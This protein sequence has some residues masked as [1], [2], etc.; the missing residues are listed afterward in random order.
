MRT[1]PTSLRASATSVCAVLARMAAVLLVLAFALLF[2][3]APALAQTTY[4]TT[5][6]GTAAVN[7]TATPCGTPLTR[8]FNVGTSFIVGD[9]DLGVLLEH[10]YRADIII[11]LRSPLGTTVT[12][13]N[14]SGGA[15]DNLNVQFSDEAGTSID[16]DGTN[17]SGPFATTGTTYTNSRSPSA[18]GA[19][20]AFDGENASGSWRLTICD[21]A[22]ADSGTFYRSH[23]ILTPMPTVTGADLSLTK[24]VSNANP[25]N[26]AAISYTLS[27][28]NA[29]NSSLAASGVQVR[30]ILPAGFAFTSAAGFGTYNSGTGIWTVGAIPI[31]TTRTITISGTVSAAGGSTVVNSAEITASGQADPDSTVNNGA[32]GEDDYAFAVFTVGARIAGTP[33]GLTCPIGSS[34]QTFDW[35]ASSWPVN[36]LSN[37][38]AF[39]TVGNTNVNIVT[40][41]AFVTGSP[42]INANLEGGLGG[43]VSLFLNLNNNSRADDAEVTLTLPTAVPQLQFRIHDIDFASGSFADKV[44]VIGR[45]N[46]ATVMPT[47]TNGVSNYVF[48]NI[49]IGDAGSTDAGAGSGNGNVVVTFSSPVDTVVVIYGNHSTAPANP[50]NQWASIHDMNFCSPTA[51]LTVDKSSVVLNDPVNGTSS[52][53]AIPGATVRYCILM[54]N[55]GSGTT[56]AVT[57]TDVLPAT[58]TF[59]PGSLRTGTTCSN[60]TTVEDDDAVGPDENNPHGAAFNAGTVTASLGSIAPTGTMAVTFQA[61]VN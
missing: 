20:S 7:E 33:P 35:G 9:V 51:T 58:V 34:I 60:A 50:G 13:H 39:S 49:A 1:M 41:V 26:G 2:A 6:T 25:A 16:A 27:V 24:T 17:H 59:V 42:A 40:D 21:N 52:P 19:L 18:G 3:A 12:I 56:S 8:F 29:A 48:G 32:T 22:N 44:T 11:Q 55:S 10:T 4:P 15:A 36:S 43:D 38:L 61:I 30:D 23:L 14:Q 57:M 5:V 31:G 47:L 37:T 46:G 45:F 53:Y 28:T 54:T